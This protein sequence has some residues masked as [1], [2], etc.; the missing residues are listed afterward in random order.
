LS[1]DENRP[2][3]NALA[4]CRLRRLPTPAP[5]VDAWWCPLDGSALE[6]ETCAGYLSS[7]EHARAA[8]CGLAR[9]RD[10]YV[11][12]RGSLRMV[13]GETL[14]LPPVAV[15]IIRGH[16]GRPMLD[17]DDTLDFNVSHTHDIAL[18]GIVRDAQIGVDVERLDRGINV[19]GIARKFLTSSERSTLAPLDADD[20]RRAL[21]ALW[22]CKEAMSKAT[23][24]ALSAP[25]SSI[26][27]ELRGEPRVV[28]GAG[29]YAPA[30]WSLHRV[31][32]PPDYVATVALWRA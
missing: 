1:L 8:R 3:G 13:L 5:G 17:A 22:T 6:L 18:I 24:D 15:P 28:A 19:A 14:G 30:S 9:L 25:F 11:M 31:N 21:L 4:G 29:V 2:P 20:A 12:G 16:R 32:G 7:A 23:G 26:G 27:V 10:R